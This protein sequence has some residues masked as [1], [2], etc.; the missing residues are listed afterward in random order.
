MLLLFGFKA[1]HKALPGRAATCSNCGAFIHHLLEEQATKF[2]LFFI[3][4][5][6]VSRKFRITCTNCGYVSSITGRQKRALELRR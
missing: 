5:L 4:V 3:P 6:T 1:V 2:T